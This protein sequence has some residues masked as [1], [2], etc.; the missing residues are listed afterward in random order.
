MEKLPFQLKGLAAAVYTPFKSNGDINF[1]VIS[2]YI[3]YLVKDGVQ[4]AFICGSNGEGISLTIQ[5]R[6]QVAETW[7]HENNGRLKALVLHVGSGGIRETQELAAHAEK[8]GVD[9][10]ASG[11]PYGV[12]PRNLEEL[13]LY[14]Q[15]VASCAPTTPFYY[16]HLDM[17]N[18]VKFGDMEDFIE[19][20]QQIPIPTFCGIKFTSKDLAELAR[21]CRHP[22][23]YQIASGHDP[24]LL[25]ALAA[26]ANVFISGTANFQGKL[27]SGIMDAFNGGD[28]QT[29]TKLYDQLLKHSN[30]M[31]KYGPGVALGKAVTKLAR[32]DPG[33]PRSPLRP[34]TKETEAMLKN[35][36]QKIGFFESIN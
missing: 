6:K 26:G 15:K 31:R 3:D 13:A 35:D 7:K 4:N 27:F 36:L 20:L 5:E 9:A 16:Y 22:A 32:F 1:G 10:I 25:P 34:V 21:C 30:I 18:S 28:L 17:N 12:K 24:L 11:P 2:E 23:G 19:I 33:P 29:A 8:V 14:L